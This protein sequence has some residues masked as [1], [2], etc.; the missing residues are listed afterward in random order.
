MRLFLL[1]LITPFPSQAQT[2]ISS[3]PIA[4]WTENFC[5]G[6]NPED[7]HVPAYTFN[8]AKIIYK[9]NGPNG[10]EVTAS[11]LLAFRDNLSTNA[12]IT[13]VQHGTILNRR[14]VPSTGRFKH[15]N[16]VCQYAELDSYI[17]MPDFVGMGDS[18]LP[19]HPFLDARTEA[20]ASVDFIHAVLDYFDSLELNYRP[21]LAITGYSQGG[22]ATVAIQQKIESDQSFPLDLKISIPIAGPYALSTVGIDSILESK[23]SKL[24][25]IYSLYILNGM[26]SNFEVFTESDWPILPEYKEV[27]DYVANGNSVLAFWYVP[28]EPSLLFTE[29]FKEELRLRKNNKFI[30]RL[31]TY[32][33]DKVQLKTRTVL[34]TAKGDD[35][36]DYRHAEALLASQNGSSHVELIL[37]GEEFGHASA[38]APAVQKS[39]ELIKAEL[40]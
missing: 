4:S 18:S 39:I 31:R 1:L 40:K 16:F 15:K 36:V 37:L 30:E 12:Y 35:I 20:S 23:Y 33:L 6:S 28:S 22:H 34:I 9:T 24:S 7:E 38:K 11:G 32:D 3:S 10:E 13:S 25:S 21:E 27:T 5:I 17:L 19:S 14:D 26:Q 29:T 8:A 2:L